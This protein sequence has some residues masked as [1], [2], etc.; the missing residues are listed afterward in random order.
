[1]GVLRGISKDRKIRLFYCNI[2]DTVNEIASIHNFTGANKKI[3]AETALATTVLS[4][5]IKEENST[6]SAML[7]AEAPYNN[8]VV[9]TNKQNNLKAYS[10]AEKLEKY[11]FEN[12]I[13]NK[14]V[15]G[16]MYDPGMKNVYT[17]EMHVSQFTFET[18]ISDY[19]E[20]SLQHPGI[21]HFYAEENKTVGVLINPVLNEEFTEIEERRGELE[22]LSAALKSANTNDEAWDIIEGAGFYVT[23]EYDMKAECDCNQDKIENVIISIGKKEAESILEEMGFIEVVCPYCLKK[24]RLNADD[25]KA[26]F[27][28]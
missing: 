9:V 1:M 7:R 6:F 18:C 20:Q 8:T 12:E 22:D 3:L 4:A 17:N 5:D 15:F 19:L 16:I 27:A 11:D 26:L 2:T 10:T 21:V 28:E 25:V 14:A 24:Y 23:A 13:R